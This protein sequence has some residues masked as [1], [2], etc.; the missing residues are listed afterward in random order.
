MTRP[1]QSKKEVEKL[2]EHLDVPVALL[3]VRGYYK[4]MGRD[5]RSNDIG[6]YDDGMFVWSEN[7]YM[8][9]NANTDPSIRRP[10]IAT[11]K[12]GVWQ[13]RLGTHNITK[14][15]RRQYPALVQAAPVTVMR[16][17]RGED[18][19]WFGINIH[20]GSRN[21]TSSLGCITLPPDVRWNSFYNLVKSEMSRA[22]VSRVPLVL[23]DNPWW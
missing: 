3:A 5:K 19:G 18:T 22:K 2:V 14:A 16:Q 21:T 12:P 11:L 20:K 10:G 17:G 15:R 13:Y 7:G 23:V 9:F 6:I 8:A 4:K 1:K